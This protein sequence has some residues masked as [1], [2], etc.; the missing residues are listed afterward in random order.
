MVKSFK[1]ELDTENDLPAI[2]N[3]EYIIMS[4]MKECKDSE[5]KKKYQEDFKK[6]ESLRKRIFALIEKDKKGAKK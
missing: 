4:R 5:S 6:L 1:I 2:F 3:A